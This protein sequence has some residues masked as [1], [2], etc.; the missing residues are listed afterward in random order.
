MTSTKT[1][2]A[3]AARTQ[4]AALARRNLLIRRMREEG[5]TLRQIGEV[6]GLTHTAIKLILDARGEGA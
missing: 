5:S 6:C 1:Q 3:Q 4:R 2:L